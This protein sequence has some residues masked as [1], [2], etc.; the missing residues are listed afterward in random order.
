MAER[1]KMPPQPAPM[2]APAR[3]AEA[4]PVPH[5]ERAGT[6]GEEKDRK[7]MNFDVQI[8]LETDAA[9]ELLERH[10]GVDVQW[11][12]YGP[13]AR[14]AVATREGKEIARLGT[15]DD[16]AI[17]IMPNKIQ[18]SGIVNPVDPE[19]YYGYWELRHAC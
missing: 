2:E 5:P 11:N 14:V 16:N 6:G 1:G 18:I 3:A 12:Q 19:N 17:E 7:A 8:Y 15:F 4:Q 10:S 9:D 13:N